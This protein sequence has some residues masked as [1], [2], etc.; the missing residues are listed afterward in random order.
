MDRRYWV[1]LLIPIIFVTFYFSTSLR[2]WIQHAPSADLKSVQQNGL[3]QAAQ[4]SVLL[5]KTQEYGLGLLLDAT[6]NHSEEVM[7]QIKLNRQIQDLILS[8]L[9][10]SE[11]SNKLKSEDYSCRIRDL[12]T[13]AKRDGVAWRPSG[14][15][16]LL[17][18]CT[19]GQMSNHQICIE[20]HMFFAALLNRTL[21]LPS[22]KVDYNYQHF[23]DLAHVQRCLGNGTV[24]SFEDFLAMKQG[25]VHVDL[26]LCY[27]HG[28][29]LDAEHERKWKAL[30]LSWEQKQDAWP[31][32]ALTKATPS[33]PH[34][35]EF[36]KK[37]STD[38]EVIAIG[39]VYYAD[40][41]AH[42][43]S[44]PGG[45]LLHSCKAIIQPNRLI[46]LTAQRFVQTFL[47]NNFLSLH[48]RRH[49]F[50]KFCNVKNE[51]CF[52]PIPQ[53][54]D[55]IL[56]KVRVSNP[57]VIYISTDAAESEINLLQSLLLLDGRHI[58]LVRRPDHDSR[59]KWDALLVRS[60]LAS[61]SEVV[62]MLDKTISALA[63]IFIGSSGSTF[64][65][66]ILRLRQEWGTANSC[67][68]YLCEGERPNYL[69]D[70]D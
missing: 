9:G 7:L 27:M 66:D 28:C 69:A 56:Q 51:S 46:V 63:S 26:L 68:D 11:L 53:A 2:D 30:G 37:F 47:G 40:V 65:E 22:F 33:H 57:A 36:V 23:L 17:A 61:D 10:N 35:A 39:D 62:A 25:H 58:P 50:L 13:T 70:I 60:G 31:E 41:E 43:V 24:I 34:A 45:P 29:Y 6:S 12:S 38:L 14:N 52:F 59:E 32:E 8:S 55:C 48:F 21:V 54:A 15:R 16:Y 4:K 1:I 5:L 42:L 3:M 49:G 20:K 64:T 44:Q 67:D 18:I 19:S